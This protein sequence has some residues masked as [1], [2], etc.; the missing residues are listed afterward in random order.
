MMTIQRY[1]GIALILI[2][3]GH[4]LA[5]ESMR[6]PEDVPPVIGTA[7]VI[8]S[9]SPNPRDYDEWSIRLVVPKIAWEVIGERRPKREWPEFKVVVEEA[10]LTLSMG[11]HPATQL[12]ENAQ[13]RIVDLKGRRLNRDE[14]RKRLEGNTPVLV[15]VSGRM[16]DPY[17]LQCTR[18]D[19]LIV[20]LGT[21]ASP[22]PDLLPRPAGGEGNGKN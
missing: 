8:P 18:N 14:A 19:A 10:T 6:L 16:P 12:S 9:Q 11:Y 21:P 13:N 1:V 4:V 3:G 20:V 15:S 2:A 22:A 7:V 17:F 5:K